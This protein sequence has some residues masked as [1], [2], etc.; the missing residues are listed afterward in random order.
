MALLLAATVWLTSTCATLSAATHCHRPIDRVLPWPG[1]P[2]VLFE[3]S[4]EDLAELVASA[5]PA[6]IQ[7]VEAGHH[8]LFPEPGGMS[9]V[10]LASPQSFRRQTGRDVKA[11]VLRDVFLSPRLLEQPEQVPVYLTHE[12]SHLLIRQQLGAL[13]SA[14]L[15]FCFHEGLAALVSES[16]GAQ[17]VSETEAAEAILEG[18]HFEPHAR[19][20][21]IFPRTPETWNLTCS[22]ARP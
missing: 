11:V 6:S 21:P 7:Q 9:V 12:P 5:L 16:G 4:G 8:H 14:R 3:P 19:G 15:P 2:R 17:R 22:T 1:D 10:V 20:H 18:R 13:R